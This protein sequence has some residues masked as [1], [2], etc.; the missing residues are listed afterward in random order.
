MGRFVALVLLTL[1]A[2]CGSPGPSE[3]ADRDGDGATDAFDAQPDQPSEIDA[4]IAKAVRSHGQR[5]GL[6]RA[7]VVAQ[8]MAR[9]Q[10]NSPTAAVEAVARENG[11]DTPECA[12]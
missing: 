8:Y 1:V 3:T 5:P 12:P 9:C 4:A 6:V 11:D 10:E 2:G 7:D